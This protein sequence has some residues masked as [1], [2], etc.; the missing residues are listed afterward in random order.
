MAWQPERRT[1]A[2]RC[3][4]P[5]RRHAAQRIDTTSARTLASRLTAAM[6]L[7]QYRHGTPLTEPL[8]ASLLG[9]GT[10]RLGT[11]SMLVLLVAPRHMVVAAGHALVERLLVARCA[12]AVR[13][14]VFALGF[15]D[16]GCRLVK[17]R[18][19]HVTVAHVLL[20]HFQH[21]VGLVVDVV[22]GGGAVERHLLAVHRAQGLLQPLAKFLN[23]FRNLLGAVGVELGGTRRLASRRGAA[24]AAC[25]TAAAPRTIA[26]EAMATQ[27]SFLM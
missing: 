5:P 12:L 11:A 15:T 19:G 10:Q 18:L 13:Y 24:L 9:D 22:H 17:V 21:E 26:R 3:G 20:A 8:Q 7:S 4:H 16:L 25:T 23:V 6:H 27:P 2:V 1:G 14:A